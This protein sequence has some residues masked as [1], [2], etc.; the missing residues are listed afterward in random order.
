MRLEPNHMP[1]GD[2]DPDFILDLGCYVG[3]STRDLALKFPKASV[4]A[5][6]IVAEHCMMASLNAPSAG[7]YNW[8]VG[9]E[10]EVRYDY[11]QAY[12]NNTSIRETGARS[13]YGISMNELFDRFQIDGDYGYVKMDIEGSEGDVFHGGRGDTDMQWLV[14][15]GCIKVEI[16]GDVVP[17]TIKVPLLSHGFSV[18]MPSD[19]CVMGVRR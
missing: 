13:V 2:C 8:A 1:P 4:F 14:S 18:S 9:C 15:V 10:G 7:V 6:D 11:D 16:H 5:F 3:Y 19:D 17:S 12:G